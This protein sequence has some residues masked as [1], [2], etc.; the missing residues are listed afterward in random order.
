LGKSWVKKP[1]SHGRP[2]K[3]LEIEMAGQVEGGILRL[4]DICVSSDIN[5]LALMD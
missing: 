4:I 1:V 3:M 5:A 2:A